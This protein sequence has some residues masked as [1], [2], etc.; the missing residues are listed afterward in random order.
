MDQT[1]RPLSRS[2]ALLEGELKT[3]RER[4][5]AYLMRLTPQN[6]LLSH[7]L[8]AGL[9]SFNRRPENIHWGW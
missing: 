6:L 4:N 5:R 1:F 8:E 3:R 7:Y 2:V 9:I